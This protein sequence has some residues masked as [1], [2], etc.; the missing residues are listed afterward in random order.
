VYRVISCAAA[1]LLAL[2]AAAAPAEADDGATCNTAAGDDAIRACTHLL[3]RNSRN[4]A[5]YVNRGVAYR[6]R[7]EDDRALAD[8]DQAII[9]D[10]KNAV[11][12]LDRGNVY[13]DR[14]EYDRA[15]ADYSEAIGSIPKTHSLTTTAAV[16]TASGPSTIA[17]LSTSTGRSDSVR[18]MPM[19]TSPGAWLMTAAATTTRH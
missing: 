2:C 14:A 6:G 11:A 15:L 17:P 1:A 13:Y 12:Y 4:A 3:S 19:P 7:G 8:Y 9:V 16:S 10:P 5:A 18:N